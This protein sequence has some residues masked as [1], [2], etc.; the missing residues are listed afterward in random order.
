MNSQNN[1]NKDNHYHNHNNNHKQNQDQNI[2]NINTNNI[3]QESIIIESDE[4]LKKESTSFLKEKQDIYNFN[5]LLEYEKEYIILSKLKKDIQANTCTYKKGYI[6]QELVFC[7]TC[8][9]EKKIA[10]GICIGC[11]YTCH[12]E[13]EVLNLGFKKNFKCDCGNSKFCN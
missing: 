1:N 12:A 6:E 4:L 9:N 7:V 3:N 8:Y 5:E 2:S 13:H 11:S 10:S